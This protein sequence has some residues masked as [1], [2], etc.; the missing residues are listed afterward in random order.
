MIENGRLMMAK[1][2]NHERHE[3]EL[4]TKD[5]KENKGTEA[6]TANEH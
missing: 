2:G 4:A 5:R 3:N 6:L 1:G